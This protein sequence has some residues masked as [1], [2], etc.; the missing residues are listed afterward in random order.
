MLSTAR[1]SVPQSEH[2]AMVTYVCLAMLSYPQ[3]GIGPSPDRV[4]TRALFF[5]HNGP[6][7]LVLPH[8]E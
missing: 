3:V 1:L 6:H 7:L 8:S 2:K 4:A 5:D